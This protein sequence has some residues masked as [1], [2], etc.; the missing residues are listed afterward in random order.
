MHRPKFFFLSPQKKLDQAF[1]GV[2]AAQQTC[3]RDSTFQTS[4]RPQEQNEQPPR[5]QR[6]QLVPCGQIYRYSNH[7]S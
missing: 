7:V 1:W 5:D 3:L 2:P 6:A 4:S